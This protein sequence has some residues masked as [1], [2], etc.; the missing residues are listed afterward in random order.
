MGTWVA[1]EALRQFAITGDR[2]IGGKL[3]DVV[4]ASPDIDVD[5]FKS[6]MADTGNRTSRSSCFCRT[7]TG[8]C[9]FRA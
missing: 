5:V 1:L 8:R 6:Q 4:L 7:T 9:A 2:D 3:G